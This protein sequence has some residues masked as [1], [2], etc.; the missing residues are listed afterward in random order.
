M[1]GS[2]QC[3]RRGV[4]RLP[5]SFQRQSNRQSLWKQGGCCRVWRRG[6]PRRAGREAAKREAGSWKS[7]DV[8]LCRGSS[9]AF[10]FP[11]RPRWAAWCGPER[12][13]LAARFLPLRPAGTIYFSV[14]R[15]GGSTRRAQRRIASLFMCH[16]CLRLGRA[17]TC[18]VS[19]LCTRS[20][21]SGVHIQCEGFLRLFGRKKY[22]H[23]AQSCCTVAAIL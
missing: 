17:C 2:A 7:S 9:G 20:C 4:G 3:K 19:V 6:A 10:R 12:S 16:R 5:R 22:L 21:T 13:V 1:P 8:L 14:S 11:W 23:T 15:G 18:F